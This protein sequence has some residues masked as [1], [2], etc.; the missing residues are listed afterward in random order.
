IFSLLIVL[1][2]CDWTLLMFNPR[3]TIIHAGAYALNLLAVAASV[4]AL[5]VIWPWLAVMLSALQ[6]ALN[7]VVY[8]VLMRGFVPGDAL[9]EGYLRLGVLVVCLLALAAV[10]YLL[11]I[12]SKDSAGASGSV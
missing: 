10:A 2:L 9:P 5:W 4:L 1:S 7:V 3:L 11:V 6:V 12:V 8:T